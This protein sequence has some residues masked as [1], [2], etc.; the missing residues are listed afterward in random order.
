MSTK[1]KSSST[2]PYDIQAPPA[3]KIKILPDEYSDG[4]PD[5]CV[6]LILHAIDYPS[7]FRMFFVS[8]RI[9]QLSLVIFNYRIQTSYRKNRKQ[10]RILH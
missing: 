8:K 10:I 9:Y 2:Y 5:D 1:R 7:L 4:L 6:N 3:K